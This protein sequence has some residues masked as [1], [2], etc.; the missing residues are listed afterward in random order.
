MGTK[1]ARSYTILFLKAPS[2][3]TRGIQSAEEGN[4]FYAEESCLQK[5]RRLPHPKLLDVLRWG[6]TSFSFKE[7][8]YPCRGEI[9]ASAKTLLVKLIGESAFYYLEYLPNSQIH[10]KHRFGRISRT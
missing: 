2:K 1:F 3:M 7:L 9:N 6:Q 4:L 5:V 10:C 8:S